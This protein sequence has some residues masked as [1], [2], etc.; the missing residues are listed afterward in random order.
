MAAWK[1]ITVKI[2][3]SSSKIADLLGDQ[4]EKEM[5]DPKKDL[6]DYVAPFRAKNRPKILMKKTKGKDNISVFV[7]VESNWQKGK[8]ANA[9][10]KLMFNFRG[11]KK[12]YAKMPDTFRAK[13]TPNTLST[14]GTRGNRDPLYIN[15]SEEQPGI[16]ARNIEELLYKKYNKQISKKMIKSLPKILLK[17]KFSNI[18]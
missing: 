13:T 7:G 6:E 3:V 4:L 11:T 9:S 12:R 2:P 15:T 10:D 14:R 17:A 18:F 16:E 5:E 8:K 1:A